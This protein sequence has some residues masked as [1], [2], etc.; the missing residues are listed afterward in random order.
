MKKVR[1]K[2]KNIP[3]KY[4]LFF[5]S[6]CCIIVF[7]VSL[8]LNISGGPL[9]SAAGYV[10]VPM[11]SGINKAGKWISRQANDFRTL[12]EVLK[13]NEELKGQVDDLTEQLNSIMLEQYELDN[14]RELLEL[15][16]KYPSY[17]KIAASVIAK[18]S[19]NWFDIFTVDR[20]SKDGIEV[21]M[22]VMADGGLVG[23]VTEVGPNYAQIR[24]IIND[25]SNVSA[26]ITTTGDNFNISG[27]LQTMNESG[28]ISFSGLK[29][30]ENKVAIGDPVVTS[31]VSDQYQQGILIGYITSI[32]ENSNHLTKTGTITP[33]VDFEH[34]QEVLI[35]V[36]LK[37]A[38]EIDAETSG[39]DSAENQ[40]EPVSEEDTSQ[41]GHEE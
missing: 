15:D 16:K 41:Q 32:E 14:L 39:A 8:T 13:E 23:I 36:S 4:T 27:N 24:S 37:D 33:V 6:A 20:G 9:H 19:G 30:D 38:S 18:D 7:L 5:L 40:K 25:S 3:T 2:R 11:Q 21:G 31:Y 35:I 29:D 10:F 17:E 12:S 28:V 22:N 1:G 34:L 26:M